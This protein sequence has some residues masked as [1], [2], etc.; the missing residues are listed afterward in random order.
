MTSGTAK[1]KSK[2]A[3]S[4]KAS[5]TPA[6]A[7]ASSKAARPRKA[8]ETAGV[9]CNRS[10]KKDA[11]AEDESK[12]RARCS[13]FR[14]GIFLTVSTPSVATSP[15]QPPS[16]LSLDEQQK[17]TSAKFTTRDCHK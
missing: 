1:A 2:A 4:P 12:V 10:D 7:K 16:P 9:A 14:S 15:E 5:K 13:R 11:Q 17:T 6:V 3:N 8:S